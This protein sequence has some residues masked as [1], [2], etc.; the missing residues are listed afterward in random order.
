MTY[1]FG[2]F[3]LWRERYELRRGA[4]PVALEPRV[5]EVLAY[6]VH[7][8]DRVVPKS[9]L[10]ASLWPGQYVSDSALTRTIGEARR[11]LRHEEWIKTVYGRGFAFTAPVVEVAADRTEA[12]SLRHRT[13]PLRPALP[14]VAVLPFADLSAA[15][16]QGY[17]C[18]GLAEELIG[19]LTGIDGLAVGSRTASFQFRGAGADVRAIAQRLNVAAV[20]E[21]SVRKE[22][23]RLRISVQ[24]INAADNYHLWAA[25]FDR[26]VDD[27]FAI[28]AE[29]AA[30][31]VRAL[32]VVLTD[33]ETLALRSA[34][35]AE[36]GAYDYY[37]RA[38]Q[39]CGRPTG[40]TLEAARQCTFAP[41]RPIPTTRP[42]M[43]V[44]PR[45]ARPS[46]STGAAGTTT[47]RRPTRPATAP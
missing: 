21:G 33:R 45:R 14:S 5:F 4:A 36:A 42:R 9:E 24:L 19:A 11:A 40:R 22:G 15:R 2:D 23:R 6:L 17:F 25:V 38:R 8:R 27:V 29:V 35:Q 20:L 26:R 1:R 30:E 3:E 44:C 47:S 39:L 13:Q 31:T 10:L 18:D 12:E 46:I 7:H 32:R 28:Q 41:S 16:D 43:R 37:L 34:L